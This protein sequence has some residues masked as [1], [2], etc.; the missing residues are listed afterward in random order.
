MVREVS[1]QGLQ[2]DLDA[3]LAA[4]AEG[5]WVLITREGEPTAAL[6]PFDWPAELAETIE[7]LSDPETVDTVEAA[8]AEPSDDMVDLGTLRQELDERRLRDNR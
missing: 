1:V 7:I 6:I 3:L 2:D 5:D 4:V 8:L